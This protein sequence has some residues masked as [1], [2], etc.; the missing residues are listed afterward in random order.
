MDTLAITSITNFIL[1]GELFFLAGLMVRTPKARFSAAWFWA[2]AMLAL[3]TSALL[4]GI[5]HGFVEP[6][7]LDRY[8]IQRPNWLVMG[9]MTFC[10]LMATARQFLPPR[11]QRIVFVLALV[12]LAVY[13]GAVLLVG[14]FR[15]VI[16]SYAPVV[17]LLL[18]SSTRGLRDGSGSWQMVLGLVLLLAATAVQAV[19]VDALEPLDH[20]G[21]YHV[22][23]MA[24]VPFMYW[25]GQQLDRT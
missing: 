19:G 23:A 12:Q 3:A 11:W 2:G 13:A 18:V 7:G 8:W 1:A 6:A 15:V 16:V 10:T 17:L 24:G 14:D 22:I 4:G 21:L 9:G 20:D 5:D 25:G